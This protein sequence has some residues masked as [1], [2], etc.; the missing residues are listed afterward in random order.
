MMTRSSSELLLLVIKD[1]QSVD[2]PFAF[3]RDILIFPTEYSRYHLKAWISDKSS[4]WSVDLS[5]KAT[6][7]QN[8]CFNLVALYV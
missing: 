4:A 1:F 5:V 6:I 3:D 8:S 7:Q 2:L